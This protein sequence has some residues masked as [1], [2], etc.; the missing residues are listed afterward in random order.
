MLILKK[1]LTLALKGT[2]G[3]SKMV[4]RAVT[5]KI[6]KYT[7]GKSF[8]ISQRSGRRFRERICPVCKLIVQK[9]EPFKRSGN[10]TRHQS[11]YERTQIG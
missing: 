11:C 7:H 9:G 6:E 3:I 5:L 1:Q 10:T 8:F 4:N 2:V